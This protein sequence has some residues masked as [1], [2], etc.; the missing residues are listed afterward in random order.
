MSGP[1]RRRR[2]PGRGVAG[3]FDRLV[4]WTR[5]PPARSDRGRRFLVVQICGCSHEVI[6]EATRGRRMPE[7][8]RLIRQGVLE[9]HP[10]PSGLPDLHAGVPG[11]AHVRRP[12]R[13]PRVRVRRQADRH[14]PLV[15]AAVGRGGGGGRHARP[16]QGIVRG[17]RTYGC[18]FG[19]GA[20]DTVLTF[21]HVL[22]AHAFWGRVGFR[23]L[24]VPVLILAWLV[25]KMSVVVASAACWAGS[26]GR[27][28]TSAWGG[29]SARSGGWSRSSSSA[30]G[31]GS[32]SPW[33]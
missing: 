19:G 14:V 21:A 9:L 15:S 31:C 6:R 27:S 1:A 24:I 23:A 8:G 11:G 10:V 25:A 30:A 3:L 13:R 18:V 22:R 7:L 33:A 4:R 2:H 29:A 17:G 28:A 5:M 32:S 26:A 20:D 12:G 16:G